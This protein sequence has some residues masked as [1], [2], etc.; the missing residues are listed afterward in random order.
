MSI[1]RPPISRLRV[2]LLSH[3]HRGSKVLS[4]LFWNANGSPA[5]SVGVNFAPA[6]HFFFIDDAGQRQCRRAGM[7][8]L[9]AVGG[10]IVRGDQLRAL[11]RKLDYGCPHN[12][13]P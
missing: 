8:S 7:G 1:C 12:S 5:G 9:V 6:M 13:S 2:A 3:W 11:G 4:D 10:I